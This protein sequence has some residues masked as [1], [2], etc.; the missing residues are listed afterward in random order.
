MEKIRISKVRTTIVF[1][2][3]SAYEMAQVDGV[4]LLRQGIKLEGT[5]HLTPH[6]LIFSYLPPQTQPSSKPTPRELWVTYPMIAFC[7]YRPAP[8][9]SH[10]SPS[11]RLRCRD[12]VFVAFHFVSEHQARDV[13]D[14]IKSLTCKLGKI[15]KLYA[16][17]YRAQGPEKEVNG[18]DVYDAR[19]EFKRQGISEKNTDRGWRISKIN[20]NYQVCSTG[21]SQDLGLIYHPVF[22]DLSCASTCTRI[23]FGQCPK[24]CRSISIARSH[25]HFDILT[26]DQ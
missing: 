17:S 10:Q 24:L 12:F 15:E 1:S 13:Y 6:H 16:F 19:R 9:A 20:V 2:M 18:W 21:G 3:Q 7:S 23:H 11:I 5:L 22:P 4:A 26:S 14:S 25:T 8:P